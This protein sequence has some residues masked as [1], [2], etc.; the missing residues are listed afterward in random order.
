MINTSVEI[1]EVAIA[2]ERLLE[3]VIVVRIN[4]AGEVAGRGRETGPPPHFDT[5]ANPGVT[6]N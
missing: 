6:A 5:I 1:G 2:C 3:S 4:T